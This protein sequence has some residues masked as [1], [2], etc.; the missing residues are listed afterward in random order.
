MEVVC[1]VCKK[2][3]H[4]PKYRLE[5]K[6]HFTC[7]KKCANLNITK[8]AYDTLTNQVGMDFKEWLSIKYVDES[9][10][11]RKISL[12]LRGHEKGASTISTWLKKLDI[13]IRIGSDA[14][15]T[16]WIDNEAR[17]DLSRE[18]A[19]ENLHSHLVRSK[20]KK[21]MRTPEV[22]KKISEAN[23]GVN[24]GMY[25][26][27]EES[28]PNWDETRTHFLRRFERKTYEYSRWRKA[29][30]EIN[31]YT[32]VCCEDNSGGN[33]EAHHLYSHDKY[34]DKR[35]DVNNGV[36]LCDLCHKG[37]HLRYGYGNNTEEQF[38][39]YYASSKG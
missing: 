39:E 12:L 11:T 4:L 20:M 25:G 32:C 19:R 14:V 38:K 34:I 31:E 29:V 16:Q 8:R 33:L 24:N 22:R 1:D 9:L 37:F 26:R 18:I 7:S 21:T 6:K 2:E 17:R 5:G 3:F 35:Y 10:S 36:T 27:I 23:K 28:H 15:K 13:P 30:F